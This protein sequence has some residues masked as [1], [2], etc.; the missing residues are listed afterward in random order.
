MFDVFHLILKLFLKV[1]CVHMLQYQLFGFIDIGMFFEQLH[2]PC[3]DMVCS[4]IFH[5]SLLRRLLDF[6]F[7][8]VLNISFSFCLLESLSVLLCIGYGFILDT[9]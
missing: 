6:I 3:T 4:A 9:S 5:E 7:L 1:V 8:K 2:Q